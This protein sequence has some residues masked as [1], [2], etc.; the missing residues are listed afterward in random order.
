[1]AKIRLSSVWHIDLKDYSSL[2]MISRQQITFVWQMRRTALCV[3]M[4]L[5]NKGAT[6]HLLEDLVI[7]KTV[8]PF[9][10]VKRFFFSVFS[11]KL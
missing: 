2:P 6:T 1:M 7:T 11:I 9:I 4:E 3:A 8:K 10:E 5:E